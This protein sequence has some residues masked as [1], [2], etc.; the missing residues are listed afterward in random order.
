MAHLFRSSHTHN[1]NGDADKKKASRCLTVHRL[2]SL[3]PPPTRASVPLCALACFAL[4]LLKKRRGQHEPRRGEND[5][6]THTVDKRDSETKR[7]KGQAAASTPSPGKSEKDGRKKKKTAKPRNDV[8]DAPAWLKWSDDS[9]TWFAVGRGAVCTIAGAGDDRLADPQRSS[10][11]SP[12]DSRNNVEVKTLWSSN[13][14]PLVSSACPH[15]RRSKGTDALLS[16][17]EEHVSWLD[18]NKHA[19]LRRTLVH[20][21]QFRSTL[22]VGAA[23]AEAWRCLHRH[24]AVYDSSS[25][26]C[27]VD[28]FA[29]PVARAAACMLLGI[30]PSKADTALECARDLHASMALATGYEPDDD[31]DWQAE[32][33]LADAARA[34]SKARAWYDG[35]P[36]VKGRN[37]VA[38]ALMSVPGIT[39]DGLAINLVG[40]LS[41]AAESIAAVIARGALALVISDAHPAAHAAAD[42]TSRG[43]CAEAASLVALALPVRALCRRVNANAQCA[44]ARLR[45]DDRVVLPLQGTG[46]PFGIGSHQCIG[47]SFAMDVVA[48]ALEQLRGAM[49]RRGVR[50]ITWSQSGT[51]LTSVLSSACG[52]ASQTSRV[53]SL[54]L[55]FDGLPSNLT[56][57]PSMVST[58]V[59]EKLAVDDDDDDMAATSQPTTSRGAVS[60]DLDKQVFTFQG[61]DGADEQQSTLAAEAILGMYV[62]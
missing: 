53:E 19:T 10:P 11:T 9:Q 16:M 55:V 60:K 50:L 27:A 23:R 25:T 49:D 59:S 39:S 42:A 62:D 51:S 34:A 44:G 12:V 40:L 8:R 21:V 20:A 22:A 54:V 46:L 30:P 41:S 17:L 52:H 36:I 58:S 47:G 6:Q 31:D 1:E 15:A 26:W 45:R 24:K 32:Q 13:L 35:L 4:A 33:V 14:S 43:A 61:V 29:V 56:A 18:G 57:T 7:A 37:S 2:M 28:D 3:G 38:E 5:G 48:M